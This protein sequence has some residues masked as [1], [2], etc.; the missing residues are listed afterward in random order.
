MPR[1]DQPNEMLA[2]RVLATGAVASPTDVPKERAHFRALVV[3]NPNYFGTLG[4]SAFAPVLA[5]NGNTTYEQIKCVGFQPQTKRLDAVVFVKQPFGYG[6]DICSS[7]TREYV[8]FYI[9]LDNGATWIDQGL[10]S[11]NANDVPAGTTGGKRLEYAVSVPCNP[12]RKF[13]TSPNVIL[14]RAILSW[15]N[16]PTADTPGFT[17]VWGNVH[18]TRIQVDPR[19]LLSWLDVFTAGGL[20]ISPELA[21]AID[22]HQSVARMFAEGGARSSVLIDG[23]VETVRV[24]KSRGFR[25]GIA[26]N[27]TMAGL[28]ASLGKHGILPQFAF[29]C[30][31]DSAIADSPPIA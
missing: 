20:K 15:Q 24:L 23:T 19:W 10:T 5:V 22:L 29:T 11:F 13:C 4:T 27:D 21:G 18:D 26:T 30:G 16:V 31:C 28:E 9:S 7:G 17:P 2:T 6:G 12:P 14:A 8:R 25:M 3:G 1:H